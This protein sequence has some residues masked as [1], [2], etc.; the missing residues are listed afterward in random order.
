VPAGP[1]VRMVRGVDTLE[2]TLSAEMV[3]GLVSCVIA[4]VSLGGIYVCPSACNANLMTFSV[5]GFT[6]V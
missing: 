4:G 5:F 2:L 1:C 6:G 3:D